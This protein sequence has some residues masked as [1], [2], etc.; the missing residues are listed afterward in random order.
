MKRAGKRRL[1]VV[2]FEGLGTFRSANALHGAGGGLPADNEGADVALVFEEFGDDCA[3]RRAHAVVQLIEL[4]LQGNAFGA[5][6]ITM[7]VDLKG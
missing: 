5:L 2:P 7:S 1:T 4:A 3:G 6:T